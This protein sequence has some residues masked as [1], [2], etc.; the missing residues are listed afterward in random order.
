MYLGI[1]FHEDRNLNK[2][3]RKI[4]VDDISLLRQK[5]N[6]NNVIDTLESIREVWTRSKK[7][8]YGWKK[9]NDYHLTTFYI[10]NDEDKTEK[11]MFREFE[12]D[13]SVSVDMYA[14]VLVPGKIVTGIC[15]TEYQAIENRCPHVTLM[16]NNCPAKTSN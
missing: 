10:G 5:F 6:T 9:P 3:L 12:E 2:K 11:K 14:L 13:Q 8:S 7:D 4:L 1:S 16:V 15:F